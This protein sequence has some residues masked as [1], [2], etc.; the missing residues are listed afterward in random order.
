MEK[1]N[2]I[3]VLSLSILGVI[4]V[5][6]FSNC[7]SVNI[8]K[9]KNMTDTLVVVPMLRLTTRVETFY[10][11]VTYQLNIEHLS[12]GKI[13]SID[14]N[15][16]SAYGYRFITGLPPGE[17]I[18]REYVPRGLV[19]AKARSLNSKDTL[20]V[21]E[22]KISVLPVKAVIIIFTYT[23]RGG[24]TFSFYAQ[25]EDIDKKQRLRILNLLRSQKNYHFWKE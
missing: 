19:K 15:A 17:Y 5:C 20:I 24:R 11:N 18:M 21:E 23:K 25:F 13:Y 22:G 6:I 9:P 2:Q 12:T 8:P 3:K 1:R 14:I 16:R 7:A 4:I 10:G